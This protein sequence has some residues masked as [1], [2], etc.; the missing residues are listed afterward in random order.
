MLIPR[1][2]L[3]PR[4]VRVRLHLWGRHS[5]GGGGLD[6]NPAGTWPPAF[7]LTLGQID[8]GQTS[9]PCPLLL[10]F[11]V[12]NHNKPFYPDYCDSGILPT[13]WQLVGN[14]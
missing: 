8:L 5:G 11:S 1:G 13:T 7:I 9:G 14:T 6:R 12:A 4:Y 3:L 10:P 2:H